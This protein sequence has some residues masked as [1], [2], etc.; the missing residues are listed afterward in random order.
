MIKQHEPAGSSHVLDQLDALRILF[1]FNLLIVHER[2]E[3]RRTFQKLEPRGIESGRIL[4]SSKIFYLD[5]MFYTTSVGFLFASIG[6]VVDVD[7]RSA[8]IRGGAQ[9]T[10]KSWW[11]PWRV[12]TV[13][14]MQGSRMMRV[15]TFTTGPL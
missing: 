4:L 15:W 2:F 10:Q 5:L 14:L 8:I 12:D 13:I 9:S 3:L 1:P 11:F 6:D 7:V